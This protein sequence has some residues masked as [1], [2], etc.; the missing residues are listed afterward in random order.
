MKN[1]K[2]YMITA[3]THIPNLIALIIAIILCALLVCN[4]TSVL[5][6]ESLYPEKIIAECIDTST[7]CHDHVT[8]FNTVVTTS[9]HSQTWQYE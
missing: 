4:I 9:E 1:E 8:I 3:I 6:I 2:S 7:S 5:H